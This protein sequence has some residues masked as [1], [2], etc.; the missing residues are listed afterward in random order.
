LDI[1]YIDACI[2]NIQTISKDIEKV[3]M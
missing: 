1:K 3:Q 2:K